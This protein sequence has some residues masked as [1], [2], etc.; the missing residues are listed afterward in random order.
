MVDFDEV[1]GW[2]NEIICLQQDLEV[3]KNKEVCLEVKIEIYEGKVKEFS[4]DLIKVKE[5]V[6]QLEFKV[7][8]D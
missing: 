8:D 5:R 7:E 4:D 3:V 1:F 2:K 6:V